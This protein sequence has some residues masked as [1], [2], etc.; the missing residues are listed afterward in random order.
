M[1]LQ[2]FYTL[3][4]P[5]PGVEGK[6]LGMGVAT[7]ITEAVVSQRFPVV[8]ISSKPENDIQTFS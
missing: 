7:S 1:L 4:L 8:V 3:I 6:T 5:N 2:R